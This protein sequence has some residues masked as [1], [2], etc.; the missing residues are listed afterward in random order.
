MFVRFLQFQKEYSPILVTLFGIDIF[1]R[2]LQPEKVYPL[3]LVILF[4]IDTL[5]SFKQ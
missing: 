5:E 1:V 2:L 4:G 3:M